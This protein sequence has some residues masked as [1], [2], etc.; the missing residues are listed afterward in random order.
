MSNKAS[1]PELIGSLGTLASSAK[2]SELLCLLINEHAEK[3]VEFFD[4]ISFRLWIL[5]I[6]FLFFRLIE[7]I[8]TVIYVTS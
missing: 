5:L 1:L 4:K 2:R 7:N 6:I 3:T 8:V